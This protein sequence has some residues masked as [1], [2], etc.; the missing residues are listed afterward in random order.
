MTSHG[1][2]L[3]E[4]VVI[5]L[6][7]GVVLGLVGIVYTRSPVDEVREEA[8]RLAQ[9]LQV[10]QGEA[11]TQGRLYGIELTADAYRFLVLDD[12]NKLVPLERDELLRARRMS[13]K[14]EVAEVIIEGAAAKGD[15]R[16]V[17]LPGGTAPNF[18]IV[19]RKKDARWYVKGT[20][21]GR[22]RATSTLEIDK[23]TLDTRLHAA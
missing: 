15:A 16:I 6:I 21:D 5:L 1:F 18:D 19:L 2:T 12:D 3:I 4:L 7:V 22:I 14:I 11:E 20:A 8:E 9:Q 23:I 17:F 13:H 10:L